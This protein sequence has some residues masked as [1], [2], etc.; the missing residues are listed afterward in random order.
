[1]VQGQL[2]LTSLQRIV[3]E[4]IPRLTW[5]VEGLLV[6]G[7]RCVIYGEWGTYK[8]FLA[9]S[10]GLHLAAGRPWLGFPVPDQ[11]R[12]LY[13][14]EEMNRQTAVRRVH[15]LFRGAPNLDDS[16]APF[17]LMSRQGLRINEYE[18]TKLLQALKEQYQFCPDV[19]ILD[20]LRRVLVGNENAA[21]DVAKFWTNLNRL[22]REGITIVV[23]HHMSKKSA[24]PE[25]RRDIRDRASGSTDIMAGIDSAWA[26]TKTAKNTA[27]VQPV[28]ARD[29]KEPESFEFL[30]EDDADDEDSPITLRLNTAPKIA[31]VPSG[32]IWAAP[33]IEN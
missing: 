24:N 21:E 5:D 33:F 20:A 28:K 11:R 30:L 9:V 2:E 32:D 13:V 4:P 3:T 14:D 22:S 19:I 15:R 12:V 1:M 8:T 18:G 16:G 23:L 6:R 27:Q 26:L 25:H 29:Q 17:M 31:K 7:D 10:L